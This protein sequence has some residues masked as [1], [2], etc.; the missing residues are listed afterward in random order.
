MSLP[1]PLVAYARSTNVPITLVDPTQDDMPIVF[2]NAAMERLSGYP[3]AELKGKNCRLLQRDLRAQPGLDE[4][5]DF[6]AAGGRDSIRVRL[7]NFRK[8]GLPFV[9]LLTLGRL[10]DAGGDTR[11]FIGSQF[12]ISATSEHLLRDYDEALVRQMRSSNPALRETD[13]VMAETVNSLSSTAISIAQARMMLAGV[14][15]RV[16]L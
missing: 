2:V 6:I 10:R 15:E 7:I 3:A 8:D 4:I 5:R 11:Y 16:P 13:L 1:P 12:D 14:D 9:N